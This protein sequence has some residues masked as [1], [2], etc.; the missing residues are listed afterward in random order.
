MAIKKT[1]G[2]KKPPRAGKGRVAAKKGPDLKVSG[3]RA[4][5]HRL[6]LHAGLLREIAAMA[7]EQVELGPFLDRIIVRVAKATAA[8]SATLFLLDE[9][10]RTLE[11]AVVKGPL[12]AELKGKRMSAGEGIAGKVVKSGK[13]HIS[14][15]V[16]ADKFWSPRV[17]R[18]TGYQTVN[19]LAAPLKSKGRAL[20]VIELINKKDGR[21]FTRDDAS[22]LDALAAETAIVIENALLMNDLR[23]R[24]GQFVKLS[25]LSAILNS[26][27]NP[28]LVR[29]RAMEAAVELLECETGSLYLI[30][31][32][33]NE[34]YFEVALGEKGDAVKEIRLK[35][36]EG[37]AGWVAKEGQSDLVRDTSTDPRWASRVDRKSKFQTRNMVTVPMRARGR[38]IGVLQAINKLHDKSFDTEDLRLL[39]SLADQVAIALENARLYEEQKV[40]FKETAEAL[41]TAIEKR[42]PY[43]GGHTKRVRDYCMATAKYMDLTPEDREWLEL[44]AILHD[45]GK[46]GV[47]DQ[48]LR[49]PGRLTDDEFNQMKQHPVFGFDILQHVKPLS[50]AIPGMKHHHERFDGKGYPEG[51]VNGAIPLIA[52]I[53]AVSDTWDAMTSDR[54]YRK[55]LSHD[56]ANAEL[57]KCTGTQFDG[58]VVEAF[59]KAYQNGEIKSQAQE[60]ASK[61]PQAT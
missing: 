44:A 51:L 52:R 20:G 17:A 56:I 29:K 1:A 36:G 27:L 18:E 9:T 54:P 50:P 8:E 21:P 34:L 57:K 2:K 31:P 10:G 43:T 61:Q 53:I 7:G 46:I 41:A 6:E 32:E 38:A 5:Y 16:S 3:L 58:V 60:G 26:T 22:L 35:M 40:M 55:G 42:D 47:D 39:E 48:V 33:K 4:R 28:K 24:A 59:L 15:Q 30:D 12:A 23:L 14:N 11:F 13:A 25:R 45:A 19:I 37:I 49:K